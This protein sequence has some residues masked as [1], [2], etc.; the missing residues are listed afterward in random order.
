MHLTHASCTLRVNECL[1]DDG[2]LYHTRGFEE[3]P[4]RFKISNSIT[5][6]VNLVTKI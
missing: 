4:V 6:V 2:M 1:N 5:P 3:D